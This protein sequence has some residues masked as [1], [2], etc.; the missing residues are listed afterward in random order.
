MFDVEAIA[1]VRA[2]DPSGSPSLLF[3]VPSDLP[4][5]LVSG[6]IRRRSCDDE[7][8]ARLGVP[9]VHVKGEPA[10]QH[11]KLA[12]LADVEAVR[13]DGVD[14]GRGDGGGHG[15]IVA[16]AGEAVTVFKN[17]PLDILDIDRTCLGTVRGGFVG[18]GLLWK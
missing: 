9:C 3:E 7:R 11:V 18:S 6:R 15:R 4:G 17:N 16:G 5:E 8:L 10:R 13:V 12:V 1:S 2:K 14:D